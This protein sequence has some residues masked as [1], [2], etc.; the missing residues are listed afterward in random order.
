[1]K[2]S[3]LCNRPHNSHPGI[4]CSQSVINVN[5][6]LAL[7]SKR[8]NDDLGEALLQI[9]VYKKI[10]QMTLHCE[11]EQTVKQSR[12]IFHPLFLNCVIVLH[13]V[14]HLSSC[15]RWRSLDDLANFLAET[16]GK[17][18]ATEEADGS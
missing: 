18:G 11:K 15:R 6:A 10:N 13:L 12:V 3:M 9:Y 4:K 14:S 7:F 8:T 2:M 17:H 5:A 1:M 16:K